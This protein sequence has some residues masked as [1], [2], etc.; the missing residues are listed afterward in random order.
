MIDLTGRDEAAHLVEPLRHI[1][2]QARAM[3]LRYLVVGAA[4]RD[5]L[6]HIAHGTPI[7]RMT[8]DLDIAVAV[9]DWP[10]YE[11]LR[12]AFPHASGGPE[13][14][15]TVAD[16][17]VDLVPFGGVERSDRTI[18]WPPD[19]DSVMSAFGLAE[20]LATAME[21]RLA[22]GLTVWVASLPAQSV[23]KLSAWQE[24]HFA[25]PRRDS[26]D[27]QTIIKAHSDPWNMDR[28]YT[29]GVALLERADFDVELGGAMLLGSDV[30]QIL[31]PSAQSRFA[32]LLKVTMSDT[33]GL[34]DDM[35]GDRNANAELLEAFRNGV[36]QPL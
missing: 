32:D 11:A 21:I 12:S 23:L 36:E 20:A 13:H 2:R 9:E 15:V 24:R 25:E 33:S 6:L 19:G 14:R 7:R 1:D 18:A 27:L 17:Q 3:G 29:E 31:P 5:L 4:A 28:L 10:G 8:T 26:V 35:P 22:P 16:L 30:S 34:A